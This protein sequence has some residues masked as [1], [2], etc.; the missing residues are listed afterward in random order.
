MK[1][2]GGLRIAEYAV[3]EATPAL[4]FGFSGSDTEG[5]YPAVT[6]AVTWSGSLMPS[7]SLEALKDIKEC[8]SSG[9]PEE[10][11]EEKPG[12]G[13]GT[14]EG[15]EAPDPTTWKK[16]LE[17]YSAG[18][19]IY[20]D[21]A[22]MPRLS[23]PLSL[24]VEAA[25]STVL[26][27]KVGGDIGKAFAEIIKDAIHVSIPGKALDVVKNIVEKNPEVFCLPVGP[28]SDAMDDALNE[29]TKGVGDKC[30]D[31]LGKDTGAVIAGGDPDD[32]QYHEYGNDKDG[33]PVSRDDWLAACKKDKIKQ[34]KDKLEKGVKEAAD[35]AKLCGKP[36]TV[37]KLALNGNVFMR[38]FSHVTQ[39]DTM[40]Q[41]DDKGI[42]VADGARTGNVTPVSTD[43]IG[44]HAEMYYDTDKDWGGASGEAM[45]NMLWK[46]RLRRMQPLQNLAATAAAPFVQETFK[47]MV[48]K[49]FDEILGAVLTRKADIPKEDLPEV[50]K[51]KLYKELKKGT[52]G[53]GDKYVG[54][55]T[56][57]KLRDFLLDHAGINSV[58]H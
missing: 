25:D 39:T 12:G 4:A 57:N 18:L 20:N 9:K 34:S 46:A 52:V 17:K 7:L 41:R 43:D 22:S 5:F 44:A 50:K 56:G 1:I 36:V 33:K 29:L 49:G 30:K 14:G 16:F 58:V 48:G 32:P 10:G 26:C 35:A 11:G 23:M 51:L 2:L 38:S 54:K 24:P 13:E 47:K 27:G 8:L 37:W 3:S 53:F 55:P 15:G 40:S 19:K 28:G 21:Y 31:D 42:D 45:W 6:S